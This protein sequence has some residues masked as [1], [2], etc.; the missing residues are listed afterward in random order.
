M[1]A[2]PRGG[3]AAL[4]RARACL[5]QAKASKKVEHDD[6]HHLFVFGARILRH[7]N[8]EHYEEKYD[9]TLPFAYQA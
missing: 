2:S 8:L 9:E 1:T 7:Q 4:R 6:V 5:L 3:L